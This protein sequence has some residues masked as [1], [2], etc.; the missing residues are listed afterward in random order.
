M[1][2][3]RLLLISILVLI[4]LVFLSQFILGCYSA[5]KAGARGFVK[6]DLIERAHTIAVLPFEGDN[7]NV[8]TDEFS[9]QLGSKTGLAIMER[10]QV[11]KIFQEQD[12]H[13]ERVDQSTAARIGKMLGVKVLVLGTITTTSKSVFGDAKASVRVKLV[14]TETGEVLAQL[15][16]YGSTEEACSALA[17]AIANQL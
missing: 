9:L 2:S 6:G 17:D 4:F 10:T 8:F 15:T 11:E 13:P 7:L 14:H 1:R 5:T 12:F 16:S 3:H